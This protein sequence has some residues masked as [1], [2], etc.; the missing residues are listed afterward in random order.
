MRTSSTKNARDLLPAARKQNANLSLLLCASAA[1]VL[2][3]ASN[4]S[5]NPTGAQVTAGSATFT[6]PQ[7]NKLIVTQGT[8]KAII[9]WQNFDILNGE[10]T[11]FIQ[12]SS[13]SV[14]LNR[15]SNGNPTQILG[16]LSANGKLM[17]VNPNGVFFGPNSHVDV[18]GLVASTADTKDADFLAGK[19]NFSIAGKPDASIINKGTITAAQGGLVA[20]IAPN[21]RNDGVI[22]ANMGTVALAGAQTASIDMYGD[23]LYSFALDKETTAAA[24]GSK[25][26]V[27]NNGIVS[28]GGGKVLLTAKVAKG[29]VDNVI[30]NTGIIEASSSHLEGGTVVLDGGDG[31]VNVSGTINAS[32][33]QGGNITVTGENIT[34]AKAN[35]DASGTNGGGTVKIGGDYQGKGTLQHAK[36]VKADSDT[37]INVSAK[38]SG[39]GGTAVVWSDEATNFNGTITGTGGASGGNGGLAEVSS[40]GTLGYDGFADLHAENGKSG[41]LLLDPGNLYLGNI[42][43]FTWLGDNFVK[44]NATVASLNSGTN[45]TQTA[46]NNVTVLGDIVWNGSG[47]LTLNAGAHAVIESDIKSFFAGGTGNQGAVTI[48]AVGNTY[49]GAADIVTNRGNVNINSIDMN[50]SSSSIKSF[51]GNVTINNSGRF[52]SNLA[53]V[54]AGRVV[55]LRQSTA[56]FIQ[57]AIDAVSNTGVGSAIVELG[58]GIWNEQVTINKN[59]LTVKGKGIGNSLINAPVATANPVVTINSVNNAQLQN[60]TVNG[61]EVGVSVVGSG[62]FKLIN[63]AVSGATQTGLKMSNTAHA[64]ISGSIFKGNRVGIDST[65]SQLNSVSNNLFLDNPTAMNFNG[66]K[67]LAVSGNHIYKTGAGT[68]NNG[69]IMNNVQGAPITNNIFDDT[70]NA[71]IATG[72]YSL[73]IDGNTMNNV[74]NGVNVVNSAGIKVTNS[75]MTG[76][77]GSGGAGAS[78]IQ[79]SGANHG[80][81]SGNS[82]NNFTDGITLK[83]SNASQIN[84]NNITNTV[85]DAISLLGNVH[86]NVVGNVVKTAKNGI[87]AGF[88]THTTFDSNNISDSIMGILA[89]NNDFLTFVSNTIASNLFGIVID[90]TDGAL[91]KNNNILSNANYGISILNG[92]DA[93]FNA[94]NLQKNGTGVYLNNSNNAT[95]T[96]DIFTGNVTGVNLDNSQNTKIHEASMAPLI[97]GILIQNGSGGTLVRGLNITGGSVGIFLDGAGSS[98]QFEGNTSSFSGQGSYFIL[99]NNAMSGDTLDASAQTFEGTRASDFTILQRDAAEAITTD[100]EDGIP[101]I[102]NVFYKSFP[103]DFVA[104]FSANTDSLFQIQDFTGNQGLFS[105]AGR[106]ISN[107]PG[108]TPPTFD[109]NVLNLSLLSPAAGGNQPPATPGAGAVNTA[110]LTPGQLGNLEPAAGGENPQALA[111]LEPAAGGQPNCGNSFLGVGFNTK[112]DPATCAV[113]QQ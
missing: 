113:E 48:N 23:N 47:S 4:A 17:V 57:N 30:N 64:V 52:G 33:S 100:V 56:G 43:D 97:T 99:R 7:A 55:S 77:N 13:S 80:V 53:N 58:Y 26:A 74:N 98:M 79:V 78:G 107:D 20:L 88:N 24:Q 68:S 86:T 40:K 29:V 90:N 71:I 89:Q 8:D 1:F 34:L 109:P 84:F 27:E 69:I 32:G 46:T 102:G 111:S 44:V 39:N 38:N 12:P 25:A 36:T 92:D 9:N 19:T 87:S 75:T 37:K 104:P 15:I 60:L 82:L 95:L 73:V 14:A 112:F 96:G 2:I 3:Q 28:V 85:N 5:A 59:N 105:Y 50:M 16:D 54:I 106:T 94:N 6:N 51:A 108:V 83:V 65:N 49:M 103:S 61:G 91:I 66:D 21:V 72:G 11:Q 35:L 67:S 101:T 70:K 45:V 41:T 63:S 81:I 31:N 22:Q 18:A 93:N 42:G 76:S 62:G 10:S 110:G